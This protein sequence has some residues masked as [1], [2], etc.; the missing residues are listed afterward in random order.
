MKRPTIKERE[1]VDLVGNLRL[2][3]ERYDVLVNSG[4]RKSEGAKRMLETCNELA[5]KREELEAEAIRERRELAGALLVMVAGADFVLETVDNFER[6]IK[7]A[8]GNIDGDEEAMANALKRLSLEL[9]RIV[10]V[11]DRAGDRLGGN[12]AAMSDEMMDV[13][14]EHNLKVAEEIVLKHINAGDGKRF[15]VRDYKKSG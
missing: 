13:C 15:F 9:V 6:R 14:M 4:L 12:F 8:F 5:R 7:S 10:T 3:R 1:V 2:A 11:M